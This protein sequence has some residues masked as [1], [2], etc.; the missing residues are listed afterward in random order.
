MAPVGAEDF[1]SAGEVI[2]A[3]QIAIEPTE[4]DGEVHIATLARFDA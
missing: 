1:I 4:S 2:D 3:A